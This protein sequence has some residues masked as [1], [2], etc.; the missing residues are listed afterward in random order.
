MA[1]DA[2]PL[3]IQF[4]P[5]RYQHIMT[6]LEGMKDS[7]AGAQGAAEDNVPAPSATGDAKPMWMSEAEYSTKALVLSWEGI[8]MT[9]ATWHSRW[10]YVW[11]GRIY[12]AKDRNDPDYVDQRAYWHGYKVGTS[13]CCF[14]AHA[15]A[16]C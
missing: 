6:V 16:G 14:L 5:W 9:V 10:I 13:K 15:S 1:L 3:R 2:A 7:D 4:S 11:R 8:G 12:I